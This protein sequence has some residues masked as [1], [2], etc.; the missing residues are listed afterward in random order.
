MCCFR[1]LATT[2]AVEQAVKVVLEPARQRKN[3]IKATAQGPQQPK[4]AMG[5]KVVKVTKS[6][7]LGPMAGANSLPR[8]TRKPLPAYSASIHQRLFGG[9][10]APWN[11]G[12]P[13]VN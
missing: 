4:V 8:V 9:P 2:L 12:C 13:A 3:Q 5:T 1:R 11:R 6:P 7:M 10:T